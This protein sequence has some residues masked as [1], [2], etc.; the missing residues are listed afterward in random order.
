[1]TQTY[2]ESSEDVDGDWWA[3][4][5]NSAADYIHYNADDKARPTAKSAVDMI[6]SWQGDIFHIT[7]R[8]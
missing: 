4:Y 2:E 8:P 5:L 6:R 1:M 7:D 3:P